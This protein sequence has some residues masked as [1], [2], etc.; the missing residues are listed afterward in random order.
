MK[1]TSRGKAR[2]LIGSRIRQAR[3]NCKPAVTQDDLAGRLAALGIQIDRSAISR[4]ETQ[5]RYLMD[6]EI[7]AIAKSLKV[8]VVALFEEE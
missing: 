8:S 4:I 2:N 3:L 5:E 6:Y 1:K 7:A